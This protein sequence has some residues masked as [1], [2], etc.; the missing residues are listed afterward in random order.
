LQDGRVLVIGANQ[1]TALY[2]PSNH[3]WADGPDIQGVLRN[4]FG[5]VRHA[6]FGADDAPAALMPNG[7]VLLAADAGPN[8][9]ASTGDAATGT[10]IISNIPSTAGLQVSWGVSQADGGTSVIPPNTVITSIDSR[11]QIHISNNVAAFAQAL[12]LVLE[13]SSAAPHNYLILIR[14]KTP[15]HR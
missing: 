13:A 11:H 4:P 9:I 3:T 1:H 14:R 5:T 15:S 2:N 7:H 10:A 6:N 8:P 12:N